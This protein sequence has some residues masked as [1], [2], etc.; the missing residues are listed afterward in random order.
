MFGYFGQFYNFRSGAFDQN[1]QKAHLQAKTFH[2]ILFTGLYD[3]P[4]QRNSLEKLM[5]RKTAVFGHLAKFGHFRWPNLAK[6][7]KRH[8]YRPRPFIWS[9]SQVSTTIRCRETAWKSSC[10]VKPHF[11]QIRPFPVAESG[12]NCQK[13]HL[14]ANTFHMSLFPGLYDHSLQRYSLEKNRWRTDGQTDGQTDG[15]TDGRTPRIYRPPTFG[16]GA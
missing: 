4:L 14:Q 7:F 8:I 13:A 3:H 1:D 16:V 2:M 10:F 6:T 12:Q 11:G 15:R 9:Y 5:F